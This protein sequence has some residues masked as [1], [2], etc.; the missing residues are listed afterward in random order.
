MTQLN[1]PEG[2]EELARFADWAL[3]TTNERTLK[4][5]AATKEELQDF[6]DSVLPHMEPIL[7]ACDG[8]EF[9]ALP[10]SHQGIFNIALAMA[11]IAPHVEFYKADPAVPYSF[12]ETRFVAVH[13]ADD[14]WRALPPNG[15]R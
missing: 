4:R 5:Q 11:E 12:Q 9:G 1:L 13:G 14:T 8:F 15:P 10:E 6:Y 7:D 3:M 2:F